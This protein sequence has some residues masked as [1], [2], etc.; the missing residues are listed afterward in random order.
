MLACSVR[1]QDIG[2]FRIGGEE[3]AERGGGLGLT[4][5]HKRHVT[6]ESRT[7]L[8]DYPA[9]GGVRRVPSVEDPV[10]VEL[11]RRLRRRRSATRRPLPGAPI[12]TRGSST[13]ICRAGRSAQRSQTLQIS[14]P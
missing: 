13:G 6:I 12:S 10:C 11:I 1:L 9:K 7:A 3:Y 4:T 2:L 5:I 8:F 14:T